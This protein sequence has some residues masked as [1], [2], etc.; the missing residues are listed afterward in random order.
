MPKGVFACVLWWTSQRRGNQ[1]LSQFGRDPLLGLDMMYEMVN[2]NLN[3]PLSLLG[4]QV[5]TFPL[6]FHYFKGAKQIG[7][8]LAAAPA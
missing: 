4:H 8:W 7:I 2:D 1:H 3:F 5:C 6:Q